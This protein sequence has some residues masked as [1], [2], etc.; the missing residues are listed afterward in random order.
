MQN[1]MVSIWSTFMPCTS[2]TWTYLPREHGETLLV[3]N[4]NKG[5]RLPQMEAPNNIC[6]RFKSCLMVNSELFA[7]LQYNIT[8]EILQS[9]VSRCICGRVLNDSTFH[10]FTW[11]LGK[12]NFWI[13]WLKT[14]S[15]HHDDDVNVYVK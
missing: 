12:L 14:K 13:I 1:A 8:L 7:T 5:N 11:L 15:S 9:E 4:L 6:R 2:C 3:I 10:C